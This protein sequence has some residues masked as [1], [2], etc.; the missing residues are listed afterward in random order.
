MPKEAARI[1]LRVTNVRVER[2]RDISLYDV[3]D[4]G[5]PQ[6]PGNSDPDDAVGH[7]DFAYFWDSTVRPAD[8]GLYGWAASP[9]VWVIEFERVSKEEASCA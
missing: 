6:M 9:W 4:E 1:F 5:T 8:R 2:L 7:E 3:W